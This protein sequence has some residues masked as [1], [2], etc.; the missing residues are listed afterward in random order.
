MYERTDYTLAVRSCSL[1][2][3]QLSGTVQLNH[4]SQY[5]NHY[6]GSGT[7][8]KISIYLSLLI[9]HHVHLFPTGITFAPTVVNPKRSETGKKDDQ[10]MLGPCTFTR[11]NG[12]YKCPCKAGSHVS[13]TG[14]I[15]MN[16]SCALCEHSLSIH[17]DFGRP[18]YSL[19]HIAI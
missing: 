15:D 16:A 1:L 4:G 3:R 5:Q 11:A 8:A 18:H 9:C 6:L 2:V 14:A 17:A 10:I 7:T 13:T 19:S 12:Q